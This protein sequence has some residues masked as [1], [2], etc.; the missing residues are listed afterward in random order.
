MPLRCSFRRQ[1]SRHPKAGVSN[2]PLRATGF[3]MSRVLPPERAAQ[4][5]GGLQFLSGTCAASPSARCHSVPIIQA[6]PCPL[7]LC[8]RTN[9]S[10]LA[11]D[12]NSI[13]CTVLPR[14]YSLSRARARAR[15]AGVWPTYIVLISGQEQ[16]NRACKWSLK[17]F[18]SF[19]SS[20]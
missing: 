20:V 15:A 2:R 11:M 3:R 10:C 18:I 14:V 12:W 19:V 5:H 4:R 16:D 13:H 6:T 1:D 8:F 17:I 7:L 9:Q